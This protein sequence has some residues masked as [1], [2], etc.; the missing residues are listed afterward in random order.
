MVSKIKYAIAISTL[1]FFVFGIDFNVLPVNSSKIVVVFTFLLF[2]IKLI[3]NYNLLKL[4]KF[5]FKEIL[6]LFSLILISALFT[7][8]HQVSD[9]AVTYYYVIMLFESLMGSF[10]IYNLLLKDKKLKVLLD[11]FIII[12]L[13]QS[14][15]IIIMFINPSFRD[16]V[17]SITNNNASSI[18]LRY[19]G[20]RG[21]GL[22]GSLTYDLAVFLSISLLFIPFQFSIQ[23][24]KQF[25]YTIAYIVTIIAVIMTG[26]TGMIGILFSIFLLIYLFWFRISIFS[27]FKIFVYIFLLFLLVYPLLKTKPD[28]EATFS[29]SVIPF[30][31]EMFINYQ[32]NG[33]AST[34]STDN[35]NAMYFAVPFKTFLFGDGYWKD[36]NGIGYYKNTD[37]GYMRHILYYGLFPSLILYAFYLT[38]FFTMFKKSAYF[39]HLRII[40]VLLCIY[41][42]LAHFKGD[43]LTGSSMNIKLYFILLIYITQQGSKKSFEENILHNK[44]S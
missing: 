11:Y 8:L 34:H 31:F 9:Y 42:F 4:N 18:F 22:A 43:F 21:L 41:F 12:C 30:A 7:M 23:S 29:N 32:E 27:I 15:I 33:S 14:T 20:F 3:C 37:A 26:R 35:L 44:H 16:F 5:I 19:K 39:K 13:I 40:I 28:I 25:F 1:F 38:G 6:A 17:F 24:R 36:E 2:C 10:L